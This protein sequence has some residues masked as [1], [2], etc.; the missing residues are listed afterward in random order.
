MHL[1]SFGYV[2]TRT[3]LTDTV[4]SLG[5]ADDTIVILLADHGDMLGERGLWYK[6]NFF[7]GSTRVPLRRPFFL[8]FSMPLRSTIT[9][10]S[11]PPRS[12]F[13]IN[14]SSA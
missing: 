10:N 8:A 4:A 7:E 2:D 5:L 14:P 3:K 11:V 1:A 13:A 6:M 9:S 12:D